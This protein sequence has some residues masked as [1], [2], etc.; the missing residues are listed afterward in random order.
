MKKVLFIICNLVGLTL[1]LNA[2]TT[3]IKGID[4]FEPA[5]SV[6][7]DCQADDATIIYAE[8]YNTEAGLYFFEHGG[9][10]YRSAALPSGILIRDMEVLGHQVFFAGFDSLTNQAIIGTFDVRTFWSTN[11]NYTI[12][13]VN[14][15]RKITKIAC[16]EYESKQIVAFVGYRIL[17]S[18]R[19]TTVGEAIYSSSRWNSVYIYP[20]T[21][22]K[23]EFHD[24]AV[25]DDYVVTV[26]V[27]Q[28]A[29]M[30]FIEPWK[31]TINYLQNPL[32]GTTECCWKYDDDRRFNFLLTKM[33]GNEVA[34]AFQ[35]ENNDRQSSGVGRF[36]VQPMRINSSIVV[37]EQQYNTPGFLSDMVWSAYFQSFI[38]IRKFGYADVYQDVLL[39]GS[40][41]VNQYRGLK[42][43]SV[44]NMGTQAV[45]FTGNGNGL[46]GH[47]EEYSLLND[48]CKGKDSY[49]LFNSQDNAITREVDIYP[50]ELRFHTE[51]FDIP[52]IDNIPYVIWCN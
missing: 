52:V 27:V 41:S 26:G 18:D 28:G 38:V 12:S 36:V 16:Y 24:I 10:S 30:Y 32:Y 11:I 48:S 23:D 49:R 13:Y 43:H 7:R 22:I 50:E 51:Q 15:L 39:P 45:Q 20:N 3:L 40:V 29:G 17:G 42:N 9:T 19:C 6:I 33:R 44:D 14:Y 1:G 4:S 25:T 37:K 47:T 34:S 21:N 46:V 35:Y 2:Q 5:Y 31:K 8:K